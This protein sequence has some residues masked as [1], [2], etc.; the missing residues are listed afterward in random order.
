VGQVRV[1]TAQQQFSGYIIALLPVVLALILGIINPTYMLG[2]FSKT[3]YC[4]WTLLGCSSISVL[5]GFLVIRKI[6]DIK[7]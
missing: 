7:V 4:G 5:S 3:T 2:I 1:L 6:V